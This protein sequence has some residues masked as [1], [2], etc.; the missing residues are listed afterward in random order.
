MAVGLLSILNRLIVLST[1]NSRAT[2][3][4]Q[5]VAHYFSHEVVRPQSKRSGTCRKSC[6]GS[7]QQIVG[8]PQSYQGQQP[9]H[10]RGR[11]PHMTSALPHRTVRQVSP[12]RN[13]CVRAYTHMCGERGALQLVV[14]CQLCDVLVLQPPS[15]CGS[16][17]RPVCGSVGGATRCCRSRPPPV[18]AAGGR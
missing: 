4:K 8:L 6:C 3:R 18:R 14:A 17:T 16:S 7:F 10:S 1:L 2:T 9:H 13:L 5:H 11:T 15:A 12:P